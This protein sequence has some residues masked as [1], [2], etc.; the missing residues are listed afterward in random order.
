LQI[1]IALPELESI[2]N[3]IAARQA[4][5]LQPAFDNVIQEIR[6]MSGSLEDKLQAALAAAAAAQAGTNAALA[7]IATD[8]TTLAGRLVPGQMITQADVD[9]A[10]AIAT[11]AGDAQTA[12]TA[13][14]AQ[15][16]ALAAA[17]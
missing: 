10:T 15:A 5:L 7:A 9:A 17:P 11:A 16:D 2:I 14:Q 3:M 8:L 13:A 6:T 4:V 1:T 12:A